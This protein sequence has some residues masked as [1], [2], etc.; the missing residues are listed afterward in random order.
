M[1][2]VDEP[3]FGIVDDPLMDKGSAARESLLTAW[4]A[5]MHEARSRDVETCIHLHSTSDDLFWSVKSLRIVESH[6]AA[7]LYEM[8]GTKERLEKEDKLLKASLAFSD[9]DR[10]IQEKLGPT[11]TVDALTEAWNNIGKR[12]VKPEKFLEAV[13]T[14]KHR[15]LS[16]IE[17]FG[18]ERVVLAG[19][20]CGLRGFPTYD[21][22]IECLNRVSKAVR[23]VT[24]KYL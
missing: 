13:S 24:G 1:V 9:F 4:E 7:P 17:R 2:A 20:E 22:A 10:L 12:V 15:L 8:K 6:V 11:T 23:A 16:A 18:V 21:S 5:L 14:M 19:P 3:L